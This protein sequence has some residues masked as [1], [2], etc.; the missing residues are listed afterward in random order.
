MKLKHIAYTIILIMTSIVIYSCNDSDDN[1]YNPTLS[2]DAQI[3]EF[4]VKGTRRNAIDSL[5]YPVLEKTFFIID[6]RKGLIYN[7]DSLPF[8]TRL[9]RFLPELTF[10]QNTA[11]TMKVTD[12]D[13]TWNWT[14]TDSINFAG[15]VSLNVKAPGG[16]LKYYDVVLNVHHIDPDI[17]IW[18][19]MATLNKPSG[20]QIKSLIYDNTL[21]V[22]IKE[23]N[24][25]VTVYKSNRDNIAWTSATLSGITTTSNPDIETITLFNGGLYM[26]D[27]LGNG[28]YSTATDGVNWTASGNSKTLHSIL[29]IL[30]AA[31]AAKDSL[32][33]VTADAG[34]YY[35]G[36]TVDMAVIKPVNKMRGYE[37]DT[38]V[39]E[40]PSHG[41]STMVS[42]NRNL[43]TRNI[44]MISGGTNFEG[45]QTTL[46]W[47]VSEGRNNLLEISPVYSTSPV[48]FKLKDDYKTVLYTDSVYAFTNDSIY[49]SRWGH[50]WTKASK[51]QVLDKDIRTKKN[52]SVFADDKNFIWI[53]GETNDSPQ[54]NVWRGRLNR[55]IK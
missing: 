50:N 7:P 11:V 54:Y 43:S 19:H 2:N 32:L 35:F 33:V 34:K 27:K 47:H 49:T 40:F 1:I 17:F 41:F 10:A 15:A 44:M 42:Y 51:K 20:S 9:V 30:P 3:Y 5:C 52:Q 26:L 46:T 6:Q 28:Y 4:K 36:K 37:S 25:S 14:N 21:Y 53:V 48:T 38:I 16:T 23:Q 18:N 13:S 24:A 8:G 45:K 39:K 31:N 22:Y 12:K 29:G 55:K